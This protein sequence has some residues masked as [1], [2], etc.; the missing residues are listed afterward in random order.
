MNRLLKSL[1]VLAL[2]VSAAHAHSTLKTSV[3]ADGASLSTAPERLTL[4]FSEPVKLTMLTLQKE[5]GDKRD[6]GPLPTKADATFALGAPA[7]TQG[8]YVIAWRALA[9]D[10][11]V[12]SG[13]IAFGVGVAAA[14]ANAQHHDDHAGHTEQHEHGEHP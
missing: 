9:D 5:G 4:T 13:R 6:L 1:A 8:R 11:H 3:P 14:P 7:M 2:G 10:A 12:M